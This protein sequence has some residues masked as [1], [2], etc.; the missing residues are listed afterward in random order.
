[1]MPKILLCW[2][3]LTDIKASKGKP[4]GG[5]PIA[6]AASAR[7]YSEITIISDQP[8]ATNTAYR[9][10]L[11]SRGA[12]PVH[13]VPAKLTSPTNFGEIHRAAS[14]AI[15]HVL[16][17]HGTEAALTLHLSPG[18]PAMAAVWIL[19]AKTRFPFAELIESSPRAGV[20]TVSVPFDISAEYRPDLLRKPDE[21]LQRLSQ[22]RPEGT[23]EFKD[24]IYRSA[25]MKTVVD[26]AKH[27]AIR[28][29]P[30]LIL[31]ESGTGKELFA[32][33]IFRSSQRRD[34]PFVPV[35]CGAIPP[36]LLES[37]LFGSERGAFTGADRSRKGFFEQAD[38][39]TLFLDEI[40]ELP[41]AAQVKLLRVLEDGKVRRL[42]A[43]QL[44]TVDVRLI[45]ATH[46]NVEEALQNGQ[47][48]QDLFY[49][50]AVGILHL[51]ALRDRTGDLGL[52]VDRL[53]EQV[54]EKAASQPD[55]QQKTLSPSA[56]NVL[57]SHLWPGNV[58]ELQNTL[59]RATIWSRGASVSAQD[60][61]ESL[62]TQFSPP[63]H[64]AEAPLGGG[65]QLTEFL[66]EI[67]KRH[68]ERAWKESGGKVKIMAELRGFPNSQ[69]VSNRLKKYRLKT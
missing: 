27:I 12:P 3:G 64:S 7:D 14:G 51:P 66:G 29:V 65:F 5:G 52:L 15:E 69:N 24:I 47:F 54:N 42:G 11:K 1:M 60:I 32:R 36:E 20:Q 40:G 2:L 67:E 23:P 68:L 46:R 50:I 45:C 28:D 33:A 18:T 56:R 4:V 25:K 9:S 31:G 10:W 34:M 61:R 8:R 39:G 48:R 13:F 49:R 17:K 59:T 57:L 41:P 30:V 58:R 43:T 53:L 44:R 6:R 26:R 19:L 63:T 37:E 55:Y 38:G 22:A 35:N 21:D 16:E 62:L